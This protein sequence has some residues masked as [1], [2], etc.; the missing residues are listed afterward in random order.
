MKPLLFYCSSP[1]SLSGFACTTELA[2]LILPTDF[3]YDSA[4]QVPNHQSIVTHLTA[5]KKGREQTGS[6]KN[7]GSGNLKVI[8]MAGK[9]KVNQ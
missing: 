8:E 6:E 5:K 4:A 1:P 7:Q 2:P 9:V 3:R